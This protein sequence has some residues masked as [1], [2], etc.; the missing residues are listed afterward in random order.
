MDDF[1][2]ATV[3]TILIKG[4]LQSP[5]LECW[6]SAWCI[7]SA[8]SVLAV[9]LKKEEKEKEEGGWGRRRRATL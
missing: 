9:I 4:L 3:I 5:M 1:K 7:V 6:D 2:S 8:Q